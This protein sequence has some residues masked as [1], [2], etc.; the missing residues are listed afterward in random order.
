M[1]LEFFLFLILAI[2][3]G[4]YIGTHPQDFF[5]L[6]PG[7]ILSLLKVLGFVFV[8]V[9][10]FF[11]YGITSSWLIQVF[12]SENPLLLQIISGFA[13]F[14][15]AGYTFLLYLNINR[16]G[17][18]K[19]IKETFKDDSAPPK[20]K[21]QLNWNKLTEK[22]KKTIATYRRQYKL[23]TM[24]VLGTLISM[25]I[26]IFL[27]PS[28]WNKVYKIKIFIREDFYQILLILNLI[29]FF[30]F[31]IFYF[32]RIWKINK[33]IKQFPHTLL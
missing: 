7:V 8:F 21:F 22:D 18:K 32:I 25:I 1:S 16:V 4:V 2:A 11:L 5:Q 13:W 29:L 31:T 28:Y 15:I 17:F 14:T 33:R 24:A 20:P 3:I 26:L 10:A 23:L 30:S 9:M 19:G 6:M 12:P 27:D